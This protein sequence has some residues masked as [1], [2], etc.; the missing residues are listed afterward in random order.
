MRVA[1]VDVETGVEIGEV[2]KA[3]VTE[4][5]P[6][7]VAMLVGD[8][9]RRADPKNERVGV[10]IG[11][12]GMLR[13]YTGIVVNAP[14]F[15]WREV[16]FRAELRKQV[17]AN[18]E[19]Y[20]DLNAITYGEQQFGSARGVRDVLCIYVGTGIGGGLVLDGKLYA[21]A[22]HLAGEVGHT[23]VVPGGRLC[24]CGQRGCIEA[25]ASGRNI[26]L[27]VQEELKTQTSLAIELAG[28]VEHVNASHIDAAAQKGDAYASKLWNEV[29]GHLGLVFA[30]VV[31]TLNPTRLVLGGGM[32]Q[33]C[34]DLQKR[35]M[36]R[37]AEL[38][39][40]PS[41]EEFEV[42]ATQLD[43]RAGILGSAAL[44]A[45]EGPRG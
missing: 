24:G 39:N 43:D 38:C 42:V 12:A 4:R 27:R 19:L 18:A 2:C 15:G 44:I 7:K 35:V 6:D 30:N 23:K 20:N 3:P 29:A 16:N 36:V 1:L 25:Y 5:E 11:F 8:L 26:Q 13:G 14:N 32:W 37:F 41:L 21:G 40:A 22:T 10:G 45:H 28:G 34:I 9:V 31:T 33:G 17:G